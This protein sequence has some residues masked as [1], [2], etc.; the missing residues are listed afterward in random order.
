VPTTAQQSILNQPGIKQPT[1]N[2]NTIETAAFGTL[3]LTGRKKEK[4]GASVRHG[5]PSHTH[6]NAD[7]DGDGKVDDG[8]EH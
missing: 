6:L 2:E 8:H 5:N 3:S 7:F 4:K 1:Q